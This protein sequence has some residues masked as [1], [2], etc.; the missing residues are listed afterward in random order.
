VETFER[1]QRYS[2][3][4]AAATL[5]LIALGGAVRATDSGLAC[6]TWPG[7]FHA[8]DFIPPADLHVWLEHSHRLVAGVVGLLVAGLAGWT[9]VR[10]RH[11]P[12]LVWAS[13]GALA[14]VIVQA[15][16][17]AIVV[18]RLL[19]AE[20]VTAHL[21]MAMAVLALLLYITVSLA[22]PEPG[23]LGATDRRLVRAGTAVAALCLAQILVGGHLTGVG[24]GLAFTDFPLMDGSLLPVLTNEREVFHAGHRYLGVV[25][26]VAVAWLYALARRARP[27]DPW[28]VRLAAAA[29][30][31]T[32]AQ[33]AIGAVNVWSGNSFVAVIPHLA[34]ASWLWAVLVL[35]V[36]LGGRPA[37][38]ARP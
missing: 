32:V 37:V 34:V 30:T 26:L 23:E 33:A 29:L 27:A 36:L 4:T 3:A 7:C 14:L 19:Q 22:R 28:L 13:I 12:H 35:F 6:P 10:L 1:L 20:L 18:L 11:R 31:L 21:G 24:G 8:G 5:V 16:L 9:L 25:L 38:G 17:G 15:A 2:A